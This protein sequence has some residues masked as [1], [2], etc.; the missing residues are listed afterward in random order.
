MSVHP[1]KADLEIYLERMVWVKET[2]LNFS[3]V[4]IID[5]TKP[6]YIKSIEGI[7]P[8]MYKLVLIFRLSPLFPSDFIKYLK[9]L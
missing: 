3:Y 5:K 7:N 2:E 9:N 1:F 8:N 6:D 4:L